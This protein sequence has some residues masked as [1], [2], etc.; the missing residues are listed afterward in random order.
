[1]KIAGQNAK[2]KNRGGK[3]PRDRDR[4]E[5][6]SSTVSW[7]GKDSTTFKHLDTS[8]G[9]TQNRHEKL[10]PKKNLARLGRYHLQRHGVANHVYVITGTRGK[11]LKGITGEKGVPRWLSVKNQLGACPESSKGGACVGQSVIAGENV[12]EQR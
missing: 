11:Q 12:G 3:I 7:G 2:S 1:V 6:A 5:E 4:T 8:R 10:E 9:R